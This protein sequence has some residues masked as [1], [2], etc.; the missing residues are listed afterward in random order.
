MGRF[1]ALLLSRDGDY[2]LVLPKWTG[3]LTLLFLDFKLLRDSLHARPEAHGSD[4]ML[5]ALMRGSEHPGPVFLPVQFSS[6]P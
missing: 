6:I 4:I 5:S 3:K 1:T 2:G